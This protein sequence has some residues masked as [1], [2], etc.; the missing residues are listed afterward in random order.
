MD[1]QQSLVIKNCSIDGFE[2]HRQ[3]QATKNKDGIFTDSTP[4]EGSY[5]AILDL[6]LPNGQII[7]VEVSQKDLDYIVPFFQRPG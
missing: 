7:K 4:I 3:I 2:E 1:A 5:R 6:R